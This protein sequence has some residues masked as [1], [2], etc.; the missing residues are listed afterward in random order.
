VRACIKT[1]PFFLFN[2]I[3]LIKKPEWK[4]RANNEEGEMGFVENTL[5]NNNKKSKKSKKG[6]TFFTFFIFQPSSVLPT[7]AVLVF[8]KKNKNILLLLFLVVV[9]EKS[10]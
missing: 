10:S 8:D 2:Y 1:S 7:R 6:K 4:K 9:V 3:L 5:K